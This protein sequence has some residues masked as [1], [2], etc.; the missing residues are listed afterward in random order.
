MLLALRMP[1]A[2]PLSVG[3][4][5]S[6]TQIRGALGLG[7]SSDIVGTSQSEKEEQRAERGA[8]WD[9]WVS[10][11]STNVCIHTLH[12]FPCVAYC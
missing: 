1:K 7:A 9:L 6:N 4:G 12:T 3:L 8:S 5:C 10:E 11:H 2:M